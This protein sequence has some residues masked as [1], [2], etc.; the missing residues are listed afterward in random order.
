VLDDRR[1]INGVFYVLRTGSPW[2]DLPER[3]G[4]YTTIY[5]RYNRWAKAA[6][7]LVTS[8]LRR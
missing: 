5:N 7:G 8:A 4:P 1:V 2:R 3:Y 6:C